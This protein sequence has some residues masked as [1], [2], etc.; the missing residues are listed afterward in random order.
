MNQPN[1]KDSSSAEVGEERAQT[2]ENIDHYKA[3]DEAE[4]TTGVRS[5]RLLGL[6]A[7][8]DAMASALSMKEETVEES[9]V[10]P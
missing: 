5:R 6:V 4:D 10:S 9:D 7:A 3:L 1:N 8:C 2:K